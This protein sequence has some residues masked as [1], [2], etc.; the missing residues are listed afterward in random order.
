MTPSP[1]PLI[2]A[3]DTPPRLLARVIFGPYWSARVL[4]PDKILEPSSVLATCID[5]SRVA[6]IVLLVVPTKSLP[7]LSMVAFTVGVPEELV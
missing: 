1:S 5:A 3:G 2:T 7:E 4:R 6:M